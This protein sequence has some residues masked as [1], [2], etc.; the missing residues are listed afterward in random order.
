MTSNCDRREFK[1]LITKQV[2]VSRNM[3]TMTTDKALSVATHSIGLNS[4]LKLRLA[5]SIFSTVFLIAGI[6]YEILFPEQ[7][8]VSQIIIAIAAIAVTLPILIDA[9]KGLMSKKPRFMTEQLVCLA[10]LASMVEGSFVIATIIPIIMVFG[11][12]LEEKSIMGVEEAIASLK[13]MHSN[14][15]IVVRDGKEVKIE[16]SSLKIND[17]IVCYPG[18]ILAADGVVIEGETSINQAPITGESLPVDAY[19]G[20]SVFAGT[21]NISG[22]IVVKVTK[23]DSDTVFN[24]I[25]A[26]LAEAEHSKAPIIKI[27]EK[28]LNMYFPFIIMVAAITLFLT[29]DVSRAITVL[30]ISCPCALILASPTA[31]IAALVSASR[32]G[33][34]IKNSAFL[35]LLAD[36]DTVI[37][38]KTGTVTLGNLAV[39]QI[40]Y[41][42]NITEHEL[43][44]AAGTCASGS[45]H[46]VSAAVVTYLHEQGMKSKVSG[47]QSEHH[48]KGV[49]AED[50]DNRCYLGKL[51]WITEESGIKVSE[52]ITGSDKISVWVATDKKL[53]GQILFSD[54]PRPEIQNTVKNLRSIGIKQIILLTGDKKN[55]ADEIGHYIDADETV[56]E[57]LPQDKLNFVNLKKEAGHRVMFV[58]DGINDALA[59]KASDVGVA[60][61]HGGSDIAIQN[62]DITLNSDNLDNLVKMFSLS[63]M[64]IGVINQ[65]ILIGTGFSLLLIVLASTG[66]INPVIGAIAHNLGPIFVVLNSARMLKSQAA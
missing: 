6:A 28:Y 66:V 8:Q 55:I 58:G 56:S 59:L 60:V 50:G 16:P 38:D 45:R 30:I 53:L 31:M 49:L 37:F 1:C 48:G 19:S 39:E 52:Q 61:A 65:N 62:S 40:I 42:D 22:K 20:M 44:T 29:G 36:V 15:A 34:M 11:H 5:N 17:K 63:E 24:K 10:V 64:T 25:I 9:I 32:H 57:C 21:I 7:Q 47:K 51:A 14:Y 33:I 27:I 2:K 43:L 54:T 13:R 4:I 35:E 18:E 26:L 46:P 12:L 3:V 23:L 41:Q